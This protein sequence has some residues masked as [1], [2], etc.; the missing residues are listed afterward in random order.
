MAE[1]VKKIGRITKFETKEY[2]GQATILDLDKS[3]SISSPE[4]VIPDSEEPTNAYGSERAILDEETSTADGAAP[5]S[6]NDDVITGRVESPDD[7]VGAAGA[8]EEPTVV[9]HRSRFFELDGEDALGGYDPLDPEETLEE[10]DLEQ[11]LDKDP[12]LRVVVPE[13]ETP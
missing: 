7:G 11:A 8:V 6:P 9:G 13:K 1:I 12:R 3:A 4:L 10:L 2:V 5:R